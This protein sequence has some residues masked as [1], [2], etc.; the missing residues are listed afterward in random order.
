MHACSDCEIGGFVTSIDYAESSR[1][2]HN[3]LDCSINPLSIVFSFLRND[4]A[5]FADF[6][7]RFSISLMYFCTVALRRTSRFYNYLADNLQM[8]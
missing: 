4:F 3:L 5:I 2:A 1:V 8:L 7:G 6:F